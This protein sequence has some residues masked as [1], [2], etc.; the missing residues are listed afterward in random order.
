MIIGLQ[1][2]EGQ[3]IF[4]ESAHG[5][6]RPYVPEIFTP[7]EISLVLISVSAESIPRP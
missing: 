5:G 7:Q 2:I 6:C 1:E 4:K 3:R